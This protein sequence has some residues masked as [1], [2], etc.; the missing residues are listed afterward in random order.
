[1]FLAIKVVTATLAHGLF[2]DGDV[3]ST[4]TAVHFFLLRTKIEI[5]KSKKAPGPGGG[6]ERST[7]IS[8][9]VTFFFT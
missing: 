2:Y 3:F 7:Y 6:T 9:L 4:L 8:I 1:V 5:H